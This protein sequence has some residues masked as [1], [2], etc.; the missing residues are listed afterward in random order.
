VLEGTAELGGQYNQLRAK[1]GV[2][3]LVMQLRH[4]ARVKAE[5][6]A[7]EPLITGGLE[8]SEGPGY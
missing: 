2:A 3:S 8:G 6:L 5:V 1:R 4:E 7:S